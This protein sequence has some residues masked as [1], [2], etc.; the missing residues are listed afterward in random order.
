MLPATGHFFT[1]L[2]TFLRTKVIT[3]VTHVALIVVNVDAISANIAVKDW[4]NAFLVMFLLDKYKHK[5]TCM[6]TNDCFFRAVVGG[7]CYHF[8]FPTN[9]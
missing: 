1:L 7:L 3:I 5:Q 8:Y 2:G 4:R 9:D 6:V